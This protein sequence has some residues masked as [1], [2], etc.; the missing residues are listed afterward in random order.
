M[1]AFI[2][3]HSLLNS[4]MMVALIKPY[5]IALLSLFVRVTGNRVYAASRSTSRRPSIVVTNTAGAHG[6]GAMDSK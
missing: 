3:L 1:Y 5:R 2:T 4:V 6:P